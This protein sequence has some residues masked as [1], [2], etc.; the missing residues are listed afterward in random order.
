[1]LL[2]AVFMYAV[3]SAFWAEYP[4]L[5]AQRAFLALTLPIA[6]LF[7]VAIDDQR[8]DSFKLI[9]NL[10]VFFGSVFAIIGI[11]LFF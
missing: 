5:T 3:V 11:I 1:M 10:V 8:K 9:S 4:R 2:T 7:I 6:I